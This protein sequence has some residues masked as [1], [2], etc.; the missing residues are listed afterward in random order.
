M[1]IV[2][3]SVV[4]VSGAAC[5]T[6]VFGTKWPWRELVGADEE[7]FPKLVEAVDNPDILS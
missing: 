3:A 6:F 1:L 2:L 4:S 5:Y 7:D